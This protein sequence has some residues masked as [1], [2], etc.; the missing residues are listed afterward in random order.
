MAPRFADA[1]D[2]SAKVADSKLETRE[3]WQL[4]APNDKVEPVEN[5]YAMIVHS[6][7]N[8]FISLIY[9]AAQLLLAAH[10][11]HGAQSVLQTLGLRN[12]RRREVLEKA[13]KGLAITIAIGNCSIPLA[14]LF[15]IVGF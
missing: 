12:E 14:V 10:L 9:V 11:F 13:G 8:P 6:F 15:G 7:K 1:F 5:V 2:T 3:K 4:A